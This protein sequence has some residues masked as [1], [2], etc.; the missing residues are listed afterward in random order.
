MGWSSWNHFHIDINE[1][2]I[3]EQADAMVS[4]GLKDAGYSYINIDDGYFGGRDSSGMLLSHPE[5]FA[6]GMKS[7]AD[8]I[9]SQGLKAGIYS[10]GGKNT[11]A[12]MY[13]NDAWGKGVGLYGHDT[14]DL[15]LM[16]TDW[17]YDFIKIDWCGGRGMKLNDQQRYTEIG[18][19]IRSIRPDVVYNICRWQFPGEWAL[20]VADSWRISGDIRP[21]FSSIMRILDLNAD[22]WKYSSARGFNDMD[23]LQVGRGMSYEEDKTHFT[24]WCMLNSPLLAGNDLRNMSQQTIDILTNTEI[25]ALN[26]DPLA[27]QARKLV[28]KG[29]TEVWAKPLGSVDGGVVAI[30]L[31]N[32]SGKTKTIALELKTVGIDPSAPFTLRDL[33]KKER[34]ATD[35]LT[36]EIPSHGVVVL[37]IDGN[38]TGKVY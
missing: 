16:L 19:I 8:Y 29:K 3:R 34:I 23:M 25:I 5:K 4:S 10:D 11:C 20:A 6:R 22:L 26:Q 1:Q 30:A 36:F 33:W 38:T 12:S 14:S 28:D 37:T 32:R 9:H 21:T 2:M 15:N 7:L 13:D 17:G 35:N 31:L 18:Q 24:L 27:Y